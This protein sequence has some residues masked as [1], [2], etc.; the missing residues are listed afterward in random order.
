MSRFN[1]VFDDDTPGAPDWM[2]E[3]ARGGEPAKHEQERALQG[4]TWACYNSAEGTDVTH[5][6]EDS[7][8][9]SFQSS[10][11]ATGP[12]SGKPLPGSR[13]RGDIEIDGSVSMTADRLA[14]LSA[15]TFGI[16]GGRSDWNTLLRL[17]ANALELYSRSSREKAEAR[18]WRATP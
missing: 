12:A 2:R 11:D 16:H 8:R 15:K 13:S 10:V 18:L 3:F 6:N 14:A 5:Q 7:P 4:W 17:A 1:N 9:L